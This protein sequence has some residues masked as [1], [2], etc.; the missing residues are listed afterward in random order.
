MKYAVISLGGKQHVV[1]EGEKLEINRLENEVSDAFDIK[2]VLLVVDGDTRSIG[3]P[4]VAG[5]KVAVK[6]V[7]HDK[8][9]KIRVATFKAK[10][11][12]RKVRGHRQPLT[13]VEIVSI[14]A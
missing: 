13:T 5:A 14:T 2:D 1:T 8:G 3:A 12:Q 4:L 10:S 9:D 11:R 7:S 6:V